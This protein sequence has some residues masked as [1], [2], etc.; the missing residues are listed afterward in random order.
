MT[1]LIYVFLAVGN[2]VGPQLYKRVERPYYFTGLKVSTP[3]QAL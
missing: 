2:I 3:P 1:G